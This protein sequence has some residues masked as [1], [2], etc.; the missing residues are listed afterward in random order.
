MKLYH[1]LKNTNLCQIEGK[2]CVLVSEL[3]C[4]EDALLVLSTIAQMLLPIAQ[5][6][7]HGG[8][9]SESAVRLTASPCA[10]PSSLSMGTL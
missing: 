1:S 8:L 2:I 5:S 3:K 4:R 6:R 10:I 9:G 7:S